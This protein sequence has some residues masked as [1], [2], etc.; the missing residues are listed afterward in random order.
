M[1]FWDWAEK[2]KSGGRVSRLAKES[3]VS[4]GKINGKVKRGKNA[5]EE[6]RK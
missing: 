2:R 5:T 4:L 1:E 6:G 3:E